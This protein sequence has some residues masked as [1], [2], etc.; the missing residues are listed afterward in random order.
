MEAAAQ[1][2]LQQAASQ[3]AKPANT[4]DPQQF[5]GKTFVFTGTLSL[6]TREQ[7]EALVKERGGTA[8]GSVSK[9][10]HYLVAG[11]KAGSKRVKAEELKVPILTETQF[12]SMLEGAS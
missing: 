1:V 7:A 9:N 2:A 11:E 3:G 8:S 12:K 10:T 6:F 5:A 4:F